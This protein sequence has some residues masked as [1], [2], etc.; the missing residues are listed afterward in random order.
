MDDRR[1]TSSSQLHFRRDLVLW[2]SFAEHHEMDPHGLAVVDGAQRVTRRQLF[3]M[4]EVASG[5]LASAGAGRGSRI[6]SRGET[7]LNT[8][9]VGLAASRLGS[10]LVPIPANYGRRETDFV[11]QR[12]EPDVF[13]CSTVDIDTDSET[14]TVTFDRLREARDPIP[15]PTPLAVDQIAFIGFTAGTT[16]SP[17]GVML[18]SASLNHALASW[19][20]I[21]GLVSGDAVMALLPMSYM[22][23][24]AFGVQMTAS[25]G[26]TAVCMRRWNAELALQLIEDERATWVPTVATHVVGLTEAASQL[27]RRP[28]L[29]HVKALTCG[30]SP[31][32]PAF[33]SEAE[34]ALGVPVLRAYGLSECLCAAVMRPEDSLEKR[35]RLDGRPIPNTDIEAFDEEGRIL[36][37]GTVG[38]G[39]IRGPSLFSGYF[40]D[41]SQTAATFNGA[42][43]MMTGDLIVRDEDGYVQVVGR[44]KDF[45]IRGGLNIDPVVIETAIRAHESVNDVA[46]IGLP[47]ERLGEMVCACVVLRPGSS[48][49]LAELTQYLEGNGV[50]K[51]QLPQVLEVVE[52]LPRSDIG[53]IVKRVLRERLGGGATD[54]GPPEGDST[55]GYR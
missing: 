15:P 10:V 1:D 53:K 45:I 22:S 17:K 12:V 26:L 28:D 21:I 4:A 39:G 24:F 33:I 9:I 37:R 32:T 25:A 44:I 38:I 2:D 29:S 3:E 43:F 34:R 36:P 35:I 11:L 42:G 49:T 6:V 52:D 54:P 31:M 27:D 5:Q 13:V 48:L 7:D 47:D 30:G 18:T 8:V 23:G 46:V 55:K 50:A 16:G 40:A 14:Q 20:E 41:S 51:H 19:A